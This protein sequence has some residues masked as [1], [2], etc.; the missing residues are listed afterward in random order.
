MKVDFAP[1]TEEHARI[2]GANPRPGDA[3]EA[4]ALGGDVERAIRAGLKRSLYAVTALVDGVP[5]LVFGVTPYSILGGVGVVWMLAS[6]DLDRPRVQRELLR[7]CRHCLSV[8]RQD[9]PEMLFNCVDV[10]NARAIRWLRWLGF[11]LLPPVPAGRNGEPFHP[12]YIQGVQ[13]AGVS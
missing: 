9:F 11:T 12:F 10:R 13:C 2:I 3:L 8:M 1:A 6:A 5:V 4:L 7:H